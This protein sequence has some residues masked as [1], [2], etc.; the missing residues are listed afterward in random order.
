[1]QGYYK[2]KDVGLLQIDTKRGTKRVLKIVQAFSS[3]LQNIFLTQA[4]SKEVWTEEWGINTEHCLEFDAL[5]DGPIPRTLKSL[6]FHAS[7]RDGDVSALKV[8]SAV[9]LDCSKYP[10]AL[11]TW[12]V[13]FFK[14][15]TSGK[16]LISKRIAKTYKASELL[17]AGESNDA[18]FSYVDSVYWEN[19]N[20]SG[21]GDSYKV[22]ERRRNFLVFKTEAEIAEEAEALQQVVEENSVVQEKPVSTHEL[23]R[24]PKL[25][26]VIE[27]SEYTIPNGKPPID[28]LTFYTEYSIDS[29]GQYHKVREFRDNFDGMVEYRK[30]QL[31][32]VLLAESIVEEQ[33]QQVEE[34]ESDKINI[35]EEAL[36]ACGVKAHACSQAIVDFLYTQVY[37]ERNDSVTRPQIINHILENYKWSAS[38]IRRKIQ[39]LERDGFIKDVDGQ[40][41]IKEFK[42]LGF[43]IAFENKIKEICKAR[44]FEF[45]G[46]LSVG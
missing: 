2:F 24:H 13:T 11:K 1:M 21:V 44:G 30:A 37:V 3:D 31:A 4:A 46:K 12:N 18:L 9:F 45:G 27:T 35:I 19:L 39:K 7:N 43:D 10:R 36:K 25:H 42:I 33:E 32:K 38:T 5:K 40:T 15:E 23:F 28:T 29:E 20:L 34:A 26:T 16:I 22:F 17:K 41:T 6:R 14:G 8:G